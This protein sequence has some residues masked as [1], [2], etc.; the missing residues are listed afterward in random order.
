MLKH[1]I[2]EFNFKILEIYLYLDEKAVLLDKWVNRPLIWSNIQ[3]YKNSI[4]EK[5][6][7]KIKKREQ[8]RYYVLQCIGLYIIFASSLIIQ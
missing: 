7:H 5:H 6:I 3:Q 8:T 4:L 2:N 1:I